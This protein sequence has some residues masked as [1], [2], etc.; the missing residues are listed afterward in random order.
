[1]LLPRE[2]RHT[3]ERSTSTEEEHVDTNYTSK[4]R[5]VSPYSRFIG[6]VVDASRGKLQEGCMRYARTSER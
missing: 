4:I 2:Y 1:V 6:R 3:K 5:R